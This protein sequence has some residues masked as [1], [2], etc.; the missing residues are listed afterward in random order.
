MPLATR[1]LITWLKRIGWTMAAIVLLIATAFSFCITSSTAKTA[2]AFADAVARWQTNPHFRAITFEYV[3]LGSAGVQSR[4]WFWPARDA[5]TTFRELPGLPPLIA[6]SPG[7]QAHYDDFDRGPVGAYLR[8]T[9]EQGTTDALKMIQQLGPSPS[10]EAIRQFLTSFKLP[11]PV[12][13]DAGA[14]AS[15]RRM[16]AD[17]N[18]SQ[19]FTITTNPADLLNAR[20]QSLAA[21]CGITHVDQLSDAQQTDLLRRLDTDLKTS[22]SE[23]WRTK[24]VNDLLAGLWAQVYGQIYATAI[25]CVILVRLISRIVLCL[26]ILALPIYLAMKNN[27]EVAKGTKEDA[28]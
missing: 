22:N 9:A 26:G 14:I 17:V 13:T 28:K 27:R 6:M 4:V 23:L 21:S 25:H 20:I 8:L 18:P 24:Q 15:V 1:R 11:F 3:E 10:D 12:V 2:Q 19:P 5:I 7:S 16:L